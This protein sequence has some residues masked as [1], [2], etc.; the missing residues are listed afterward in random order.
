MTTADCMYSSIT[1]LLVLVVLV[2][3]ADVISNL[4]RLVFSFVCL[5]VCVYCIFLTVFVLI[6]ANKVA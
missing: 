1:V 2:I 6:W 4:V 3:L 5:C